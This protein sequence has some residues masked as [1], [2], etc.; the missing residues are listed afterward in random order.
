MADGAFTLPSNV[1]NECGSKALRKA[2]SLGP[3]EA[4]KL[5]EQTQQEREDYEER[6]HPAQ[7]CVFCARTTGCW[8]QVQKLHVS[9]SGENGL[10]VFS[11]VR[12]SVCL[13]VA[14]DVTT[15]PVVAAAT[16]CSYCC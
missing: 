16:C 15:V 9:R 1:V 13:A 10:F 14:T 5:Q 2:A 3:D 11:F 6:Y 8:R 7:A 12:L 4:K